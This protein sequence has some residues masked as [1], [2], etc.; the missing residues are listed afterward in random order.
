MYRFTASSCGTGLLDV[1]EQ[2]IELEADI[3]VVAIRLLPNGQE[4]RLRFFHEL[5]GQQPGDF[6]VG[7]VFA[8]QL[9]NLFI[10]AACL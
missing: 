10:E 8:E 7:F 4:L 3:A 9:R 2:R 5:I 6:F 1:F